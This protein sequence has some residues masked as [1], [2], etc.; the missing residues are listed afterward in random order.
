[1]AFDDVFYDREPEPGSTRFPAP[2]GVDTIEALSQAW[3]MLAGDTRPVVGYGER[4]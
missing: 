2:R 1:M 3:E 4:N